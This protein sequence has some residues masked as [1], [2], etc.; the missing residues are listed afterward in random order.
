MGES[1]NLRLERQIQASTTTSCPYVRRPN[2]A[3]PSRIQA[4]S[5]HG[6]P[7]Q[8]QGCQEN[9]RNGRK[10]GHVRKLN[11]SPTPTPVIRC[12]YHQD[13]N[14]NYQHLTNL[15]LSCL[16]LENELNASRWSALPHRSIK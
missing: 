3:R 11:S 6:S 14:K 16:R 5:I 15:T 7:L 2:V 9:S 1:T 13:D 12:H 10:D 8:P 4:Q